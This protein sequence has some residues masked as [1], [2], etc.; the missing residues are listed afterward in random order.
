MKEY[1]EIIF[2]GDHDQRMMD[3]L[4]PL[5]GVKFNFG[6]DHD[7]K[8]LAFKF[9][10]TYTLKGQNKEIMITIRDITSEVVLEQ[11]LK[12]S[13]EEAKRKMDW[14]VNILHVDPTLLQDFLSSANEEIKIAEKLISDVN[15]ELMQDKSYNDFR[16]ELTR[17]QKKADSLITRLS[18]YVNKYITTVDI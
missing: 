10:K 2:S 11:Q 8:Y 1:L 13:Q 3:D 16:T 5:D 7:P 6:K 4:N 14:L 15:E 17:L 12:E 18:Q 9:R